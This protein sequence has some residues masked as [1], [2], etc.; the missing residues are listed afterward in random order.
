LTYSFFHNQNDAGEC[1]VIESRND[2]WNKGSIKKYA[3]SHPGD[4]KGLVKPYIA[5]ECF[6]TATFMSPEHAMLNILILGTLDPQVQSRLDEQ[7][8][9]NII[10]D[11]ARAIPPDLLMRVNLIIV[12]SPHRVTQE[13]IQS[14]PE[15][16]WIVRAGAGLDNIDLS[17][18]RARGIECYFTPVSSVSVAELAFGLLLSCARAIP[19]LDASVRRGEWHKSLSVG[20][21]LRQ[22]TMLI[23]GFGRIGREVARIAEGFGM[24]LLVADRSPESSE[25]LLAL[26]SL[27]N[28]R[29][30]TLAEGL[31][32]A[33]VLM[34]CCPL[35]DATRRMVDAH[36]L[37]CLPRGSVV[38]NVGRG[39][40][41]DSDALYQALESEHLRAVGLDTHEREPPGITPLLSHPRVVSTPHVGAQ[42][43]EA[44]LR[45]GA[46]VE[47]I[48]REK[49][50]PCLLDEEADG[51]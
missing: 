35:N 33:N 32:W 24:S 15:L 44:M 51:S 18:A 14:A 49:L 12:R 23:V 31:P 38:I 41:V 45:V 47:R 40:L 42:T 43:E 36:L 20:W 34:L 50:L 11:K 17:S 3:A 26:E 29:C 30:V 46:E 25:K 7:F 9:V 22:R 6:Q 5:P 1:D 21:E 37:A 10:T 19:S 2:D 28:T 39:E 48:I 16:R 4:T 27:R 8:T 13:M